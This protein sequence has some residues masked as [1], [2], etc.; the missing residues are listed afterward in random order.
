MVLF[1]KEIQ[2]LKIALTSTC[3]LR[4]THCNIEK[5][6]FLTIDIN[7]AKKAISFFLKVPGKYKRLELYGGEPFLQFEKLKEIVLYTTSLSSTE[8][9]NLGIHIATNGTIINKEIL[10]WLKQNPIIIAVSFN[11]SL[12]SHNKVRKYPNGKGS[13]FRVLNNI[14]KLLDTL[15]EDR[16]VIIY[17]VD[18][19]FV[20]DMVKDL[21]H[22]INLGVKIIDIECSHGVGWKKKDYDVFIDNL[23]KINYIIEKEIHK[24]NYIFHEKFIEIIREENSQK[25]NCPFYLDLEVYPDGN[26]GFYPYAFIKNYDKLKSKIKVGNIKDEVKIRNKYIFCYPNNCYEVCVKEYYRLKNLHDG[27]IAYKERER[28]ITSFFFYLY[29]KKNKREILPYFKKLVRI[30]NIFYPSLY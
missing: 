18:P 30:F 28:I 12:K 7:K 14:K 22:I 13:Y 20:S 19:V 2:K 3:T 17:C 9:K 23:T 4:C 26:L 6:S 29:K 27:T 25:I 21:L 16:V 1:N 15:G 24:K 11:G 5:G 8:N 10:S